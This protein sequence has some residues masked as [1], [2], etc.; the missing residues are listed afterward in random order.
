MNKAVA[1]GFITPET[2]LN[3][4]RNYLNHLTGIQAFWD[5]TPTFMDINNLIIPRIAEIGTSVMKI[6]VVNE[7]DEMKIL[8]STPKH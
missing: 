6:W 3:V 1:L 8:I 7:N 2:K 5:N 4:L